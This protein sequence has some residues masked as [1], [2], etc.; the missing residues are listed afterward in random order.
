MARARILEASVG[1]F[2]RVEITRHAA[3]RMEERGVSDAA[4]LRALR[5][6]TRSGLETQPGR[7][8]IR[9]NVGNTK[10]VDVV[11]Q[12]LDDRIRVLTVICGERGP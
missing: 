12:E 3:R 8:R 9:R 4:L 5:R 7:E 10:F 1:G 11:Y 2:D 6:P